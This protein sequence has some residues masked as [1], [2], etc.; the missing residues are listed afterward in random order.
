MNDV[1][2]SS[3]DLPVSPDEAFALVTEPERLR[4]WAA[5][6]ATVDL[7]AGG[8]WTWMVTPVPPT[9][10]AGRSVRSSP[11]GAWSWGGAGRTTPPFPRTPRR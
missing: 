11:G 7:R 10:Q 6:C 9:S 4:R 2:T 8:S 3:V 5:V 1:F